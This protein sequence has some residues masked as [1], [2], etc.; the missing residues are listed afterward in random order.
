LTVIQY[1]T[2]IVPLTQTTTAMHGFW[3]CLYWSLYD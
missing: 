1:C 3:L 2:L